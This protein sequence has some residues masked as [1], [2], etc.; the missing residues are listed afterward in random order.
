M[1]IADNVL[2]LGNKARNGGALYLADASTI[3]MGSNTQMVD[4]KADLS[5]AAIHADTG[6]VSFGM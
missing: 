4:N 5:G 2:F 1:T 3:N 6:I